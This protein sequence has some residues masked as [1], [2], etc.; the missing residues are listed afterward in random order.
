MATVP[1]ETQDILFSMQETFQNIDPTIDILKGPFAV[2]T[3]IAAEEL[4]RTE[5]QAAYLQT[6]YQLENAEN[7]DDDDIDALGRNYGID[8]D[9]GDLAN[10]VVTLWR[11]SRPEAGTLYT[12]YEGDMVGTEDGRYTFAITQDR[13]M[14]G[15]NADIYYNPD[16]KR[17]EINVQAE[18]ISIG[19][20][21]N[22]PEG[23]ITTL[24]SELEDFDGVTNTEPAYGGNDPLDKVQFRALLWNTVQGIDQDLAGNLI[25][26]VQG[27]DPSGIT[28]IRMI[29]SSEFELF[30]RLNHL[31]GK[32]GYD[33]Y[34][35]TD[36]TVEDVMQYTALGREQSVTIDQPPVAAVNSVIIDGSPAAFQFIQDTD[37]VRRSSPNARDRVFLNGLSLEAGQT[38]E[39]RYFYYK[40]IYDAQQSFT[41]RA[42][43]FGTDVL[44]RRG[45][46]IPVQI[47]AELV[48]T[49]VEDREEVI[50]E[51][52]DYTESYLRDPLAPT[53][54]RRLFVHGLDPRDYQEA[55][56]TSVAG[57]SRYNVTIF[58][59]IDTATTDIELIIFNGRNEFPVLHPQFNIA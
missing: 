10:V 8:P 33:V 16:T 32:T 30:E 57:V 43:P 52:I 6:I 45:Y 44:V 31:N 2:F 22:L 12:A 53:Q 49:S 36:E 41:N 55:V 42:M 7:L 50:N 26:Q 58:N 14:E 40:N 1:R 59:R 28:D 24:L 37:P 11:N 15:D 47:E 27:S 39:I 20:D 29:S 48:T 35:I 56:L 21:F 51:I 38:V 4:S 25:A 54:Y 46:P 5:T 13:T 34:V 18:A 9:V 19:E 23:V 17:Y 3:F